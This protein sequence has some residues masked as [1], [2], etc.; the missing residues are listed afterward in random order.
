MVYP[1]LP[2]EM[3]NPDTFKWMMQNPIYRK[4]ME[5]MLQNMGGS[6]A[7]PE[8]NSKMSEMMANFD[9]QSPEIR[10]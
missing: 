10:Y 6:T 3:R 5:D 9:L 7:S 2:E 4:Q 1:Y 8:W